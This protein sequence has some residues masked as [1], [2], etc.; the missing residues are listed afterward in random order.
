MAAIDKIYGNQDQYYDLWF[1]V[2]TNCHKYCKHFYMRFG[3]AQEELSPICNL[4]MVAEKY[5]YKNCP[6][7]W[8]R[9]SIEY[10]CDVKGWK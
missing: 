2:A 3:Y 4:P 5:L 8:V 9:E 10:R 1:W 7:K 6:L